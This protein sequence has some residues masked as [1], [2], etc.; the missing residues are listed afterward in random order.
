LAVLMAKSHG[1]NGAL[2]GLS[3]RQ[4]QVA[5]LVAEGYENIQIGA[6]LGLAENTV[7]QYMIHIYEKTG[8]NNRVL[9]ARMIWE[10]EQTQSSIQP[11]CA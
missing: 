11:V 1:M 4:L 2:K 9:L 3:E 7:K 8:V 10:S 5:R 6:H